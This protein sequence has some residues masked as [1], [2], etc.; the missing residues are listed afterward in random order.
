MALTPGTIL[1]DAAQMELPASALIVATAVDAALAA[2]S[3]CIEGRA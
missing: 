1:A 2:A 3:H